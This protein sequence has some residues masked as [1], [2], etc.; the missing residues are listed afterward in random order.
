MER[1]LPPVGRAA[2][3]HDQQSVF[4]ADQRQVAVAVDHG[5]NHLP[6]EGTD[7][8]LFKIGESPPAVPQADPE[9]TDFNNPPVRVIIRITVAAHRENRLRRHTVDKIG[10][11]DI[12]CVQQQIDVGK[13][14]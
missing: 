14:R 11:N 13:H 7:N 4:T 9:I 2:R 10:M 3:V 5:V 8:P 12:S 1:R 6:G